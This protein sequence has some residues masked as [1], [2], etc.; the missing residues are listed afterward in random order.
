MYPNPR[1]QTTV[2]DYLNRE[3][4]VRRMR[5]FAWLLVVG[6][7]IVAAA[8]L[9]AQAEWNAT[10][11][12]GEFGQVCVA[13]GLFS[14]TP[15]SVSTPASY[16]RA[17]RHYVIAVPNESVRLRLQ[18]AYPEF[19]LRVFSDQIA[20]NGQA[21]SFA[22][23]LEQQ[24]VLA[25]W[26]DSAML[27]DQR[28][29]AVAHEVVTLSR[30]LQVEQTL[31]LEFVSD[32]ERAI[33]LRPSE[34]AAVQ[35]SGILYVGLPSDSSPVAFR[36]R[37]GRPV[38]LDVD[39]VQLL[40]ERIG[41]SYEWVDCGSWNQCVNGLQN[42]DIDV[43]TFMT[44]TAERLNFAS[45]SVPYRDV[46]WA[47]V[48]LDS[49]PVRAN[50]F[51]GLRG[52]VLAVVDSYSVLEELEEIDGMTLLLVESPEDGLAAVLNGVADAY[53]DSLPL[54]MN[55]VREQSLTGMVVNIL[56]NE[57]G[58]IVSVGVHRDYADLVPLL[59]R[60]ILSITPG[61]RQAI[62]ESWFDPEI[63]RGLQAETVRRW[64]IL[65][66]TGVLVFV[67]FIVMCL[68]I[69]R[70]KFNRQT[71][72][73][74]EIRYQALHDSM[75]GLPNRAHI[76][77]RIA[78]ELPEHLED[79]NKLGLLFIDLDGFKAI[80]DE[81]GHD[82]G[83]ELLIAVAKRLK[84]AVRE[85]DLVARYGGDEFLVM[86][87]GI[88]AT[89]QATVVAEKIVRRLGQKFRLESGPASIGASIGV[90]IFPDHGDTLD[91]LLT[92]ADD[93]MYAVKEAGK[94]GVFLAKPL[95]DSVAAGMSHKNER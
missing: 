15:A 7:V 46:A 44:P 31:D 80:N 41:L 23:A 51:N 16:E 87:P 17:L 60:A 76:L 49:N 93:A 72:R 69:L 75:T 10:A 65:F 26:C 5:A 66:V 86:L 61:E 4:R 70:R 35:A 47:T 64:A 52:R 73:E 74:K 92:L 77:E 36:D 89:D 27:A 11:S 28:V 53:L 95:A 82:A 81:R 8:A 1:F 83:D 79:G 33:N 84:N 25:W 94:H 42:R 38:G 59:D 21:L 29:A 32:H 19:T 40:A 30:P 91:E 24:A 48:S 37:A 18:R 39:V 63:E 20:R 88:E 2:A 62:L 45:F 68:I 78:S 57:P 22:S 14:S 6:F 54:L 13:P 85:T 67:G 43:L 3:S 55:R 9:P 71:L 90:A 50:S 12:N 56:R 58:D 34:M